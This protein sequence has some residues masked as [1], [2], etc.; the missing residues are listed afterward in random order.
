M[1]VVGLPKSF[2]QLS[3]RIPRELTPQAQ[4]RVRWVNCWHTLRQQ[5]LSTTKAAEALGLSRSTL[6][7]WDK[8]LREE[9]PVGLVNKSRRPKRV[10]RPT[11]SVELTQAVLQLR[12]EYPRWGKDKLAPLLRDQGWKVST[13]MVGRILAR[14]KARGVLKEPPRHGISARRRSR[15]RPYGIRK[16]R[17][18]QAKEPGDIVQVDTLDVR[19]LPGMV[20]KHFTA[21]DV[22][23]RWDV[24]E[25]HTRAT[26]SLAARFLESMRRRFPFTIKAVQVDGGSEFMADFE[27]ACKKFGIRLFVLPPRSPKLNGHVERA[28]RTHTE[29]FYELYDGELDIPSLNQA[30]LNWE[31]IYDTYRP[32]HSLDGRT[33][34]RYLQQCHPNLLPSSLSHMY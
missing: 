2:Y 7:R 3:K 28:Q 8:A 14:L 10:R 30:L 15:P 29:E 23:S 4:E 9:G 6:Y 1:R 13:S 17:E 5:G 24:L 34:L 25:V 22:V 26:S 32:H 19:P 21:R 33:P 11:W 12:E 31:R 18:Y 20:L 27:T 16:P